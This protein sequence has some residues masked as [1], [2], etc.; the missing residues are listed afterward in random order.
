ME[1]PPDIDCRLSIL[2]MQDIVN[3]G[4]LL[5]DSL[6]LEVR[7]CRCKGPQSHQNHLAAMW[8]PTTCVGASI[9]P[10]KY[11]ERVCSCILSG[12]CGT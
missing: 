7:D 9:V 8:A 10:F 6:I 11:A 4:R 12:I 2:Q 1:A 5:T 3:Q